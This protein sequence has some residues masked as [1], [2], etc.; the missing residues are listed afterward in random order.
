MMARASTASRL[1]STSRTRSRPWAGVSS[2]IGNS[3]ARPWATLGRKAIRVSLGTVAL[4]LS[5]DIG[6]TR[7]P[8]FTPWH[9]PP[10]RCGQPGPQ[11]RQHVAEQDLVLANA[12]YHLLDHGT[13]R[14]VESI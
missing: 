9:R 8:S 2:A 13:G 3:A 6:G 10:L 1:S 14:A 4:V 12:A 5:V 7:E 11:V